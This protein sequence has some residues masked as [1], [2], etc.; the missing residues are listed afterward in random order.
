MAE[1]TADGVPE[2]VPARRRHRRARDRHG[3]PAAGAGTAGQTGAGDAGEII[4]I[5]TSGS[6]GRDGDRQA[7]KHAAPAALDRDHRRHLL[8][9]DRRQ[10]RRPT[11]SS[12]SSGPAP[13]MVPMDP[14]TRHAAHAGDRA[15]PRRRRHGDRH[16]ADAGRAAVRLGAAGSPSGT[17]SCSPTARTSNETPEQLTR[18]SPTVDRAVPVRLPRRRRRLGGRRAAPDRARRC[19][20]PSTSSPTPGE[21]AGR[22]RRADAAR[23][24]AA[25]SPTPSCGSG[26]RRAPQCSSSARSRPTV[27][28]LTARRRRGEPADRR[29]PDGLLGRRVPRL[30]RGVRL[31]AKAVGQEQL[32]AR[33]QLASAT[34]SSPRA[35]SRQVVRRRRADHPDQP[36]RSRTTPARPSSPRRSRRAWPPRRPATRRPRPPSSAAP[37]S[38]P[39]ETGNEEATTRLRKVV[40]I[41]DAGRPA[42]SG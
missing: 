31:A 4:I 30:P 6:M 1:F 18:P 22:L 9:G 40:D 13:A 41:D 26:P 3:R 7:A 27:E 20:A 35:W 37:S 15:V 12:R 29:L 34:R 21:M 32:A 16:L 28:D 42:R 33:V 5:D 10:P 39:R 36:A 2:R 17:R 14:A 38:S 23:R 19:W 24:W 11:S 25:A 8:R